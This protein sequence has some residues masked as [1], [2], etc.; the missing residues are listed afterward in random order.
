MKT[1]KF[2]NYL[3]LLVLKATKNWKNQ[4][5]YNFRTIS[6]QLMASCT[7]FLSKTRF[8]LGLRAFFCIFSRLKFSKNI[9]DPKDHY[10][11]TTA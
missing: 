3:S 9:V 5:N 8:F 6:D 4:L 1:K 2:Y 11:E 7:V 10:G